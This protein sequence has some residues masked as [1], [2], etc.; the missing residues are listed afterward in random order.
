MRCSYL[1]KEKNRRTQEKGKNQQQTQ[2]TNGNG[3]E[4]SALTTVPSLHLLYF[5]KKKHVE[6]AREQHVKY[7][8]HGHRF[9]CRWKIS[10]KKKHKWINLFL[11]IFP[12]K[13][14][15]SSSKTETRN[16][17]ESYLAVPRGIVTGDDI[18]L[19]FVLSL[20]MPLQPCTKCIGKCAKKNEMITVMC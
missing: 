5:N 7:Q 9:Q 20:I 12:T 2:P 14:L 8:M 10:P 11:T 17:G 6:F 15:H 3:P 1:R 19:A 18:A 13:S 4:A 16:L